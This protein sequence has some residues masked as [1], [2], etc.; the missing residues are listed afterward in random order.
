MNLSGN[1]ILITGGTSGIGLA[2]AQRF[3]ELGNQVIVTGRN[4][5]KLA[6]VAKQE[7]Q[8]VPLACDVADPAAILELRD[9]LQQEH[10]QLSVLV[11]NAGVFHYQNFRRSSDD[12]T[13]ITSAV[14]TNLMGTIRMTAVF[15][16]L[17]TQN[18]GTI[19]NVSS[20]L[21]FMP[22]HCAPTYCATKAGIHSFSISLREQLTNTGV[23]VVEL[24][25][26]AVDT[27][28]TADVRDGSGFKLMPL[29]ELV[30]ATIKGLEAG[31]QEIRPGLANTS[32]WLSRFMPKYL[33]RKMASGSEFLI[34]E[35]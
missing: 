17:I 26:P 10:P 9:K 16:D 29:D 5:Q 18:E 4:P 22:I 31:K 30:T 3:L 27:E 8:L 12:L 35:D 24:M 34:P 6:A 19:I 2:L 33:F 25:P 11:N 15:T 23:E 13:S 7:P 21:A 1:T 28:M 32:Y 14:E 20:G